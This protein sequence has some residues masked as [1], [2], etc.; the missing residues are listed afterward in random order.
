MYPPP[1]ANQIV[2][3]TMEEGFKSISRFEA[4]WVSGVMSTQNSV[5]QLYLVD[6]TDDIHSGYKIEAKRIDKYREVK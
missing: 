3:V 2:F 5:A 1:P 4:V 6:G